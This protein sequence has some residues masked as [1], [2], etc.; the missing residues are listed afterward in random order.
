MS[1]RENQLVSTVLTPASYVEYIEERG[2]GWVV[3]IGGSLVGLA[4]ADSREA[5]IWALFVEPGH[6]GRGLGRRLHEAAVGWLFQ[7]GHER[8][9]L[10]TEPGTRAEMFYRTAGWR[11]VG[12]L[13]NGELEFELTNTA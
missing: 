11:Q 10:S 5:R 12:T 7:Q 1:V 4:I 2:R 9:V 13:P 3:E 6:E 8:I